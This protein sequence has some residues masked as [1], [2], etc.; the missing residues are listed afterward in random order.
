VK[1]LFFAILAMLLVFGCSNETTGNNDPTTPIIGT[2]KSVK[3]TGIKSLF[4]SDVSISDGTSRALVETDIKTLSYINDA[5]QNAPVV[6][7]TSNDKEVLLKVSD[8]KKVGNK[9]L[10]A[11]YS[12]IY[13]VEET[14]EDGLT[15]KSSI[16][17]NG[18]TLVDMETG[19]LYDF[20][21]YTNEL[22]ADG[23][24]LYAIKG[25][26]TLFKIDLANIGS[27]IPLN[28]PQ[29]NAVSNIQFKMKDKIICNYL[30]QF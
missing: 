8:M 24:R 12:A 16:S 10:V 22:L 25:E 7:L 3:N 23:D 4:T 17:S 30:L 27:A 2:L 20:T 14:D 1:N 26:G 18:K 28:N 9:R 6:F 13:E 11:E 19:V 29:F 15:Y 5:G 21:G